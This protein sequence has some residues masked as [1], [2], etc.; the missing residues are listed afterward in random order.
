MLYLAS[1][2]CLVI[3]LYFVSLQRPLIS[4]GK[5]RMATPTV[6]D[7]Y[8]ALQEG[9][10]DIVRA[11][12]DAKLDI[13]QRFSIK[14]C[15][16]WNETPL[17][18]AS[19]WG[20]V[21]L[22]EML[23]NAGANVKAINASG[24]DSLM[25]AAMNGRLECCKRLVAAGAD[26]NF[27]SK[28]NQRTALDHCKMQMFGDPDMLDHKAVADFLEPL[29]RPDAGEK[30]YL[31]RRKIERKAEASK[32]AGE[33]VLVSPDPP[34]APEEMVTVPDDFWARITESNVNVDPA[35]GS[36]ERSEAR[37]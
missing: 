20:H 12:L 35:A 3:H 21:T 31:E 18:V 9:T 24:F 28:A 15:N 13:E 33:Y 2:P 4:Q 1:L 32:F 25:L 30:A 36:S 17:N 27:Q 11:W 34:P 14:E 7:F 5:H 26:P 10:V 22:L 29:T 16:A 8:E 6:K 23:L 37:E 19:M